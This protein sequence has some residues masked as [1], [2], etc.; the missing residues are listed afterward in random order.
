MDERSIEF[1]MHDLRPDANGESWEVTCAV[2]RELST[3]SKGRA[4]A[5]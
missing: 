3:H 1:K 2:W 4:Q 5:Y